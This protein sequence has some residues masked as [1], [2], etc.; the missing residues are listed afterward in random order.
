MANYEVQVRTL[1]NADGLELGCTQILST[2]DYDEAWAAS[3]YELAF[4]KSHRENIAPGEHINIEILCPVP[5][6]SWQVE[7]QY[8]EV[9]KED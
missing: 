9:Y 2:I 5:F 4:W 3:G 7:V 1:R 6:N 8:W